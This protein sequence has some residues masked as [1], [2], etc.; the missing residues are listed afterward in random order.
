MVLSY[1]YIMIHCST[2]IL[3][4]I[5]IFRIVH[6]KSK[7]RAEIHVA[8]SDLGCLNTSLHIILIIQVDQ[9]AGRSFAFWQTDPRGFATHLTRRPLGDIPQRCTTGFVNVPKMFTYIRMYPIL[10]AVWA[11]LLP[12]SLTH[13]CTPLEMA[14]SNSRQLAILWHLQKWRL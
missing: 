10:S 3:W 4:C 11:M 7:Y 1:Y 14:H 13:S 2:M 8:A 12:A 9:H 6:W 5:K